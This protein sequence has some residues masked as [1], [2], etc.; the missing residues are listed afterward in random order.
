MA[1]AAHDPLWAACLTVS[2][3]DSIWA[4]GNA[5]AG[6]LCIRCHT[7]TGWLGGHSD[8]PNLTKLA[9]SDL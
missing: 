3:Q 6:D 5:I 7:P 8:P 9:G 4:L 2:L 1:N